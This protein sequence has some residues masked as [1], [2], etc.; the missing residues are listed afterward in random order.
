M[1]KII[2]AVRIRIDRAELLREK[3]IE[4]TIKKKEHIT[5]ADLI[6]FMIDAVTERIE[7]DKNGLFIKDEDENDEPYVGEKK[8]KSDYADTRH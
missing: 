7:I 5:E 8:R 4:L 1:S 3:A 6:N 2:K